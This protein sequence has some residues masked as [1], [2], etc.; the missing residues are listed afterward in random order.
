ML[1]L[2][3]PRQVGKTT[4]AYVPEHWK[5]PFHGFN[6]DVPEDRGWGLG[7]LTGIAARCGLDVLG[8]HL[9]VLVFDE[10]HKYPRWK[11]WLKGLFDRYQ[12]RCRIVATGSAR[13][14]VFRRGGESLTGRYFAWRIHPLSV[15]EL[16]GAER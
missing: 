5:S 9:P 2:S 8:D 3:G 12:N 7:G 13:M 14:D 4:V 15:R 16:L 6:W 11:G 10:I 1:F